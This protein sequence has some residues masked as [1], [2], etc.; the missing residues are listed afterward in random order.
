MTRPMHE[1]IS[2]AL[3]ASMLIIAPPMWVH[4]LTFRIVSFE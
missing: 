4:E 1:L 2:T 3:E